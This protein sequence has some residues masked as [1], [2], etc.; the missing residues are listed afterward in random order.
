M[1]FYVSIWPETRLRPDRVSGEECSV[2]AGIRA[3]PG[4]KLSSSPPRQHFSHIASQ[5]TIRSAGTW[6]T[7][8][9]RFASQNFCSGKSHL[10]R[11]WKI[12]GKEVS[13]SGQ[14]NSRQFVGN[15]P[16]KAFLAFGLLPNQFLIA[17]L[18][19]RGFRAKFDWAGWSVLGISRAWIDK[20]ENQVR[21]SFPLLYQATRHG[22]RFGRTDL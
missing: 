15:A 22:P 20:Y 16:L 18:D 11:W 10:C 5:F 21:S 1:H 9:R 12:V 3:R 19:C 17:A 6:E 4:Q 13:E 14:P 2:L 8:R 7:R